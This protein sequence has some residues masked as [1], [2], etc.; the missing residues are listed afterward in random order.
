MDRKKIIIITII[1]LV[2]AGL[3]VAIL[4]LKDSFFL[5]NNQANQNNNQNQATVPSP[6]KGQVQFNP[7]LQL[8]PLDQ[9]L[10]N[11]SS[12][13]AERYG[14]YSTDSGTAYLDR[15]MLVATDNFKTELVNQKKAI[16]PST[17]F[18]GVSSRA[19]KVALSGID[20]AKGEALAN[21][22]VQRT[23]TKTGSPDFT[24]N[25]DLSLSL[26]KSGDQW[27]IDSAKWQ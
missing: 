12:N 5:P 20:E 6:D 15:V 4:L 7:A 13:F 27:L 9:I 1:I 8:S 18:Y 22:T 23:E 16:K 17:V 10:T 3:A 25:Q 19:L 26:K 24:Y 11:V 21:V 2:I 14:S